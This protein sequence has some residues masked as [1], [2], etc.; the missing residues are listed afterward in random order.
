L[1]RHAVILVLHFHVNNSVYELLQIGGNWGSNRVVLKGSG[2][3]Q[4]RK[5][6]G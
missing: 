5:F 6:Q 1:V 4:G 3:R 2:V